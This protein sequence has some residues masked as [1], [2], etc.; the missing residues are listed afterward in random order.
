VPARAPEDARLSGRELEARGG[1]APRT[2]PVKPTYG[3]DHG[4]SV[5]NA[6][7]CREETEN[8]KLCYTSSRSPSCVAS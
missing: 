8:D 4:S 6:V 5:R 1:G 3:T 2:V 7:A